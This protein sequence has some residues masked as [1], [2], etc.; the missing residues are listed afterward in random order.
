MKFQINDDA[1]MVVEETDGD[2][3]FQKDLEELINK[4][5]MEGCSDTPDFIL[6]RY[7]TECL[8]AFALATCIRTRWYLPNGESSVGRR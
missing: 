4:H 2:S 6:A 5:S 7:L 3:A 1:R 8:K